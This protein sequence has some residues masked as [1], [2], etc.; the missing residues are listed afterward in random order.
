MTDS[1][2]AVYRQYAYDPYGNV[3]SV[4]DKDGVSKDMSTDDFNHAYTYAGYRLIRKP[5]CIS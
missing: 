2:G 1:N 4:K 5:G 3:I